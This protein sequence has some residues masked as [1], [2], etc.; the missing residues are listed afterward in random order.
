[1]AGNPI[2]V[3]L[4]LFGCMLILVN[5]AAVV[6]TI[7]S[8]RSPNPRYFSAINFIP[9]LSMIFAALS[10]NAAPDAWLPAWLPL[11]IGACDPSLWRLAHLTLKVIHDR[12]KR[13]RE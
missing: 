3:V 13:N 1:M 5:A 9:Q 8:R 11:V 6:R 4:F 10:F 2:G 12:P 7:L